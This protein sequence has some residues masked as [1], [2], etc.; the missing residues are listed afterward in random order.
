MGKSALV[1]GATGVVGRELV[2]GLCVSLSRAHLGLGRWA[3]LNLVLTSSNLAA[4]C[5][6]I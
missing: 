2:R 3:A 5:G 1:L 6:Q 4:P